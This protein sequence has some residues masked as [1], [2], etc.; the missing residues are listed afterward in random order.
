MFSFHM[1]IKFNFSLKRVFTNT[2]IKYGYF[3]FVAM[4]NNVSFKFLGLFYFILIFYILYWFRLVLYQVI[5]FQ[6]S[7]QSCL[8]C[9]SRS[10][11]LIPSLSMREFLLLSPSCPVTTWIHSPT[12]CRL[13]SGS[14]MPTWSPCQGT[15]SSRH[16]RK[17][18]ALANRRAW[19][20]KLS[21]SIGTRVTLY[22]SWIFCRMLYFKLS[23]ILESVV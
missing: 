1:L 20:L 6:V 12:S 14:I 3:F 18:L 5:S 17:S 11:I 22:M 8:L 10:L 7:Y 23:D 16:F 21:P 4:L 15:A 2:A 13:V 19:L 9:N